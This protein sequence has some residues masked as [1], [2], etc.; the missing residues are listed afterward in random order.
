MIDYLTELL[1]SITNPWV[2]FGFVAQFIFFLRFVVQ[3]IASEKAKQTVV[4]VAFWY[5]SITGAAMLFVYS[6]K[7]Q[8]IVFVAGQG[9]ALLIYARNLVIYYRSFDIAAQ[10]QPVE[11]NK[12]EEQ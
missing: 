6:I 5:L 2:I 4:P 11:T 9:L 3:L 8:D 1:S 12:Q 7:Q 10:E